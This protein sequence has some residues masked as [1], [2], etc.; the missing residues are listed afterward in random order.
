MKKPRHDKKRAKLAA[1]VRAERKAHKTKGAALLE[2][3][4]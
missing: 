4:E 2:A 3:M 1:Q